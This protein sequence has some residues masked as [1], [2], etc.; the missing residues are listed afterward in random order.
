MLQK[1]IEYL[2]TIKSYSG[3]IFIKFERDKGS[4]EIKFCVRSI[5]VFT[6]FLGDPYRKPLA[7]FMITLL[8]HT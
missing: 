5:R 2:N 6:K 1:I 3:K 4:F 8:L 7:W